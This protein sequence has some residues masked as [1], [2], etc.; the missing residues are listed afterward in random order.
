L[1]EVLGAWTATATLGRNSQ[2]WFAKRIEE[3]LLASALFNQMLLGRTKD[4]HNAS[5]LFLFVLTRE[6]GITGEQFGQDTA[7]APLVFG[8]A[9]LLSI[10]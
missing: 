4:L 8:I 9:F 6:D 3:Q 2:A 5:Q 7:Q 10:I 1:P